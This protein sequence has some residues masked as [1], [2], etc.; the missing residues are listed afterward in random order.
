MTWTATRRLA[1][2]MAFLIG[3]AA[4]TGD[5]GLGSTLE[6]ETTIDPTASGSECALFTP[7]PEQP[8]TREVVTF[9]D[10]TLLDWNTAPPDEVGLDPGLLEELADDVAVS[11]DVASLLVARHGRLVLERYFNGSSPA[12]A[13]IIFSMTKSVVSLLTG[14]AIDDGVLTTDTAIGEVLP[15][16]LVGEHGDLRILDLLTMSGGLDY[17]P[18]DGPWEWE[19]SDQPGEPSLVRTV[20]EYPSVAEPET[21]FAY[22][23]GLTHVLGA[24]VAEA[25]GSS[26]CAYAADRLF[27]PM[28]IDVEDWWIEPGGYFIGGSGL[29]ITPREIAAL[30]QLVLQGGSWHDQQLVSPEWL[31]ASVQERWDLG[32]RGIPPDG[33]PPNHVGYGMQWWTRNID[34]HEVWNASGFAGQDLLIVPDLGLLAVITHHAVDYDPESRG[35]VKQA[36]L[37]HGLLLAVTDSEALPSPCMEDSFAAWT[38]GTDGT[39][40]APL[41]GW[42]RGPVAWSLSVNGELV[43]YS[44]IPDLNEE[45]YSMAPDGTGM[46][47]LTWDFATDTQPAWSPDGEWVAFVR[48]T[49]NESD[50]YLVRSDGSETRQVTD[51]P[52]SEQ[53]PTW[54]P[55]G[56]RL[57]FIRNTT[58]A[59]GF[60][61]PGE[62]WT[63]G[64]DGSYAELL[65]EDPVAAPMWSA[66]GSRIALETS[67]FPDAPRIG[68]LDVGTGELVELGVGALPRW[69]PDGDQIAFVAKGPD[70]YDIFVMD[71]DGGDVRDVTN[72]QVFSTFPVWLDGDTLMFISRP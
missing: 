3:L 72:G 24:V 5:S 30:G 16:G 29:T 23:S 4:C 34:G 15:D 59:N 70:N 44:A 31:H 35:E 17:P 52:G 33:A 49:P 57:A 68:Y 51:L 19:S 14:I 6:Q 46:T 27:G 7:D 60:G 43:V 62:L 66:D 36:P 25:T 38:I 11:S 39:G 12:E 50:V 18:D 58:D 56:T 32:C 8:F 42:P 61:S 45:I 13:N 67:T 48:G 26:L 40:A 63:I 53:F 54:S 1:A 65:L 21:E 64:I 22:N 37:I 71:A 20:L 9:R 28:G 69:S 2:S 55:E 41:P 10:D 47:R